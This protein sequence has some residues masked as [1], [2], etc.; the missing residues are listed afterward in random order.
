[1]IPRARL[2]REP[3]HGLPLVK[4]YL[5]CIFHPHHQGLVGDWWLW[6]C[7]PTAGWTVASVHLWPEVL[8]WDTHS[9]SRRTLYCSSPRPPST[10]W[11]SFVINSFS[12]WNGRH[13]TGGCQIL[14]R[15]HGR[16]RPLF[17]DLARPLSDFEL[18]PKSMGLSV[19]PLLTVLHNAS[20][21]HKAG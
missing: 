16:Q 18:F 1:M 11:S 20:K 8:F 6:T 13:F 15:V 2:V 7:Q 4:H 9:F 19:T 3:Q 10:S 12:N 5:L 17:P 14:R 21:N